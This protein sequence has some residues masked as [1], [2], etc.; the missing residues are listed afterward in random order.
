MAKALRDIVIDNGADT[1]KL[2][3]SPEKISLTEDSKVNIVNILNLGDISVMGN[4]SVKKLSFSTFLPAMNSIF[5]A[6]EEPQSILEKL[7]RMKNSKKVCK[8][9]FSEEKVSNDYYLTSVKAAYSGTHGDI[10]IDLNFDEFRP[11]NIPSTA[12]NRAVN[13]ETGLKDRQGKPVVPKDYLPVAG[14]E[15]YDVA[16][17]FRRSPEALRE[18]LTVNSEDVFSDFGENLRERRLLLPRSWGV[19]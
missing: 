2:A 13:D 1:V 7:F 9:Y 19:H 11:T 18:L 6:G 8:V 16:D 15:L 5:F 17:R 14:E 12:T 4:R 3:V 10:D